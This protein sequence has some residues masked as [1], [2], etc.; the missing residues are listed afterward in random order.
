MEGQLFA[1]LYEVVAALGKGHSFKGR[2]F[3]DSWVVSVYLWAVLHD[4]PTAW[5]CD[6][7]NWPEAER[8]WRVL[9]SQPTMS[10]RLRTVGV[11]ALLARAEAALRDRFPRGGSKWLDSKPLPVGGA[12]KDRDARAGRCVRGT[13]RGYK[14]HV[15]MDGAGGVVDAWRLAPM[16]DNDKLV[17]RAVVPAAAAACAEAGVPMLYLAA[18]NQYDANDLY[19]LVAAAAAWAPRLV[20]AARRAE[21]R[22]KAPGHRRQSPHRLRGMAMACGYDCPLN[23]LRR[24]GLPLTFGQQLLKD[25]G[26]IERRFGLLGN[27]GGGLGPL[28][29]WVRTPHRVAAWVQGKL[30]AFMARELLKR[31]SKNK[32]LRVA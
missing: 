30:L 32:E 10:R 14:L 5:A 12:S 2:R 21:A 22:A 4:R 28:P 19:D 3:G 25:R 24:P 9:P 8:R 20:V 1:L 16:A 18:D 11:L 26:G 31:G 27:F 17:A 13:A 7:R 29:N 6:A 23:P 15:V